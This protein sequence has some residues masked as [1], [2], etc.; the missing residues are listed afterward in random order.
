MDKAL[1]TMIGN[2]PQKTGKSLDEWRVILKEKSFLKHSEGV[3]Y[4]KSEHNVTHGFANTIVA[5]SKDQNISS[6]DLVHTQ[7]KGKENLITIYKEL[8]EYVKSLGADI[9][10]TP[11]KE[12]VSIIRKRQ[13]LLIKPATKT[14]IDLG[15]KLKD[16][17]TTKRLE[18]SGPFGTMCT[19]RVKVSNINEIDD[20]LKN[21]INEAYQKS[22]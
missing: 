21:W 6:E 19:H 4:L 5:L 1:K 7:Y 15:F 16:T 13:F 2:L 8:L 3:K 10:I 18:D 17:P 11:K 22:I 9:T 20:E 14:R 12:S